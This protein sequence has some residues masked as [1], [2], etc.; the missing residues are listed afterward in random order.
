MFKNKVFFIVLSIGFAFSAFALTSEALAAY[1]NKYCRQFDKAI[2]EIQPRNL[3]QGKYCL[4]FGEYV[5]GMIYED[6]A[7]GLPYAVDGRTAECAV[8]DVEDCASACIDPET[9]RVVAIG[10]AAYH[11]Q[12]DTADVIVYDDC[13]YIGGT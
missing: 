10:G 13:S 6:N 7:E 4:I 2:A 5:N 8:Y 3:P 11:T 9:P 12:I 1:C